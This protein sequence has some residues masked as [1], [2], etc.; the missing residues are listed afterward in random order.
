MPCEIGKPLGRLNIEEY[1]LSKPARDL[2]GGTDGDEFGSVDI[3]ICALLIA[4]F[5]SPFA[6]A[7]DLAEIKGR[8][9]LVA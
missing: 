4:V 5:A 6:R 1:Y 8:L 7:C 2:H 9:W 3:A